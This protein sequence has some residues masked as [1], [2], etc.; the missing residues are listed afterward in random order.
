MRGWAWVRIAG[1][2][3]AVLATVVACAPAA[4]LG[5]WLER[6]GPVRLVHPEGSLWHGSGMLALSDGR[7]ANLI[8]GRIAWRVQPGALFSGRI[9]LRLQH[10][11]LDADLGIVFDG[12][13]LKVDAGGA[14][15]PAAVLAAAGAPFNTVRPGGTLRLRWDTLAFREG[16]LEGSAQLDWQD[17]QSALST[18]APLGHY[19]VTVQGHGNRGEAQL[20]TLGGPLVLQGRGSLEDGVL[21]FSGTAEAQPEMRQNLNGL[22]GVLGPRMGD[23]AMLNWEM[24]R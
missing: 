8:P 11:A 3:A 14:T 24:K 4:W 16:S 20:A 17:A 13:T 21:R 10:P 1:A 12:R 22:I 23:R 9:A 5:D 2:A 6:H 7:R 19:R 18:V 15:L